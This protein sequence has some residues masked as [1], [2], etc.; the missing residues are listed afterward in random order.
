MV[1]LNESAPKQYLEETNVTVT[2]EAGLE[3]MLREC[4]GPGSKRDPI[5][6]LAQWL[7]RNNPKHNAAFAERLASM[8]AATRPRGG[9]GAES[10]EATPLDTSCPRLF[11]YGTLMADEVL[12]PLRSRWPAARCTDDAPRA[13]RHAA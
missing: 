2:V 10:T 9:G 1:L 5:N 4:S 7:M 8:R 6:F 13:Y 11:V 3:E 12:T